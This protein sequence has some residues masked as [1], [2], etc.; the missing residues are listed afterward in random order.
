[1]RKKEL[2][3]ISEKEKIEFYQKY[4]HPH[5]QKDL[6]KMQD[7]YF[8]L[9]LN[10]IKFFF[11]IGL[12]GMFVT[13]W[14]ALAFIPG[15]IAPIITIHISNTKHKNTVESL[16]KNVTFEHFLNM[17]ET[18]EWQKIANQYQQSRL[19]PKMIKPNKTSK[20]SLNATESNSPL[21]SDYENDNNL[22]I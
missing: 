10:F 15:F 13:P 16:T 17:I 7:K 14:L 5:L 3:P 4:T 20:A 19:L 12:V 21:S 2:T 8:H 9:G 22:I 11:A 1:M 6:K 18:G